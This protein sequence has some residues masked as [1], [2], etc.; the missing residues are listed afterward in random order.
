[1]LARYVARAGLRTFALW[2][3]AAALPVGVV[4]ALLSQGFAPPANER[5]EALRTQQRSSPELDRPGAGRL[6]P[7]ELA[8]EGRVLV[9]A[10]TAE[11][12]GPG[13]F[14]IV[15]AEQG[16]G[17]VDGDGAQVLVLPRGERTELRTG[18]RALRR[19]RFET[20]QRRITRD[21]VRVLERMGAVPTRVLPARADPAA[22]AELQWRLG[23]PVAAPLLGLLGLAAAQRGRGPQLL[24]A[25]VMLVA[26][27]AGPVRLREP[28]A[29]GTLP[30]V[31]GLW[32]L[33][34]V[35][36]VVALLWLPGP[37]R[38]PARADA[39]QDR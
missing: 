38:G 28:I 3:A 21:P 34:G 8:D 37:R 36:L 32:P 16:E 17:R 26:Y 23:L 18:E 24:P 6:Q 14:R 15:R 9:D 2:N 27:L 12:L 10:F 30:V 11:R 39:R 31:P 29:D 5:L 35:A 22:A 7:R 1:M 4:V 20:L 19:T 33:H 13:A 25:A